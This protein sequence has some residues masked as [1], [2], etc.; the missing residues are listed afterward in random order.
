MWFTIPHMINMVIKKVILKKGDVETFF[1]SVEKDLMYKRSSPPVIYV[2]D[3]NA[4]KKILTEG[5]IAVLRAIHETRPASVYALAKLLKR[6]RST[7]T[8][9]LR[10]LENLGLIEMRHEQGVRHMTRPIVDYDRLDVSIEI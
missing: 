6:D 4:F 5:R 8:S 10:I 7:L 2:E 3:I 1:A 9:D